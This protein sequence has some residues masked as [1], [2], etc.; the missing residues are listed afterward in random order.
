MSHIKSYDENGVN[1]LITQI[2]FNQND[3]NYSLFTTE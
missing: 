2:N 3:K 1:V